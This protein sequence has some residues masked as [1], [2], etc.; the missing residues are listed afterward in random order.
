MAIDRTN[1]ERILKLTYL[2]AFTALVVILQLA[3][4]FIKLG[5]FSISAVLV[6]IVLGAAVCGR[7]AGAWLGL[8]F[9]ITV[10]ISGDASAFLVVNP[11]GTVVTVLLKGA[12]CGLAAG[13]VY[14]LIVD[15][16]K[17]R[18]NADNVSVSA[19]KIDGIRTYIAVVAAAL[20][21]PLVNTGVFLLGTFVFF[22]DTVSAWANSDVIVEVIYFLIG[23]NWIFEIVLNIVLVPVIIRL[24]SLKRSI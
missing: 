14:R 10:L 6:P 23:F 2:A 19:K 13:V 7:L 20:V 9:G 3:G 1:R 21:C 22:W 16:G 24:L 5:I 11:F 15:F 12:L 17:Y 4:S 18:K 8:V